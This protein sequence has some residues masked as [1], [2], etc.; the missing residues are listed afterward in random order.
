MILSQEKKI[1]V[2]GELVLT[3]DEEYKVHLAVQRL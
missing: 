1:D 3:E 2:S